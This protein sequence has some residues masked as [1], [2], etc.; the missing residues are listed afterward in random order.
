MINIVN[1]GKDLVVSSREIAENFEKEHKHVLEGIRRI[2]TSLGTAEFSTLFNVSEYKAS[3]GKSNVEYLMNRDGFS[4][5][6]M[7]FTG[8]KAL[9][10][11]MKYIKAF[12]I[13]EESLRQAIPML[14][15]EEKLQLAI[16][17]ANSKDE[18]VMAS[19]ELDRFRKQELLVQEREIEVLKPKANYTDLVLSSTDLINTTAIAKD[20][21]MNCVAFNLL[22]KELKI[23]F[24]TGKQW[25]LYGK[26]DS[27]GYTHSNTST[28]RKKNGS[29][30]TALHTKWTQKG[31]IFLYDKLKS[32]G[33]LP[34]M[35]REAE[36]NVQ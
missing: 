18:A 26:Y 11:K 15:E 13:M 7:G 20:Y 8:D 36:E 16:F 12:N 30:G 10:W 2:E 6:V 3:N 14:S 23:Q 33:I 27:E 17:N 29:T 5:L 32:I 19:A 22:L 31:R 34:T 1:N 9:N 35:E 28:Y 24:K 25:F 21:G 4:L